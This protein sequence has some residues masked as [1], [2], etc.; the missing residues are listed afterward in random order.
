MGREIRQ[1][2]PNWEHPQETCSHYPSC[3]YPGCDPGHHYIPK[4][5]LNYHAEV[6]KWYEGISKFKPNKYAKY[7]HEYEGD[8]PDERHYLSYDPESEECTWFQLYETVSEGTPVSPSFAK[9]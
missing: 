8:P 9:K 7:Y 1:V 5:N 3:K 4:L 2:P 6:K